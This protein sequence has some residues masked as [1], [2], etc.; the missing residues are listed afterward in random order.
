MENFKTICFLDN[1]DNFPDTLV[2]VP[3][4][5][6]VPENLEP[7]SSRQELSEKDSKY[8]TKY[9]TTQSNMGHNAMLC[10]KFLGLTFCYLDSFYVF[11]L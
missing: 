9:N 10:V 3:K 2:E 8:N 6:A 5:P 11:C 1:L 7:R 4:E